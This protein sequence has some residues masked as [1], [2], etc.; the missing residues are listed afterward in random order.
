VKSAVLSPQNIQK[1]VNSLKHLRGAAMKFGQLVSL[2]ESVVLT[3][4]LAAI[5]AELRNTG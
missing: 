5:F 1:A 4:E 3:P 2:D